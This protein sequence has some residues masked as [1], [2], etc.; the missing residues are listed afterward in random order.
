MIRRA[1][2]LGL[3]TSLLTSRAS[4]DNHVVT[5]SQTEGPFYPTEI[6]SDSDNDLVQIRGW[7]ARALGAVLHLQGRVFNIGGALV[8]GRTTVEIWQ[9]DSQGLYDHPRQSMRESRDTAFQGYGRVVVDS[10]GRYSFRTLKPVAY[11]G[12]TPHIHLKV[13]TADGRR[14]TTQF[15]LAGDPRNAGDD[16]WRNAVWSDPDRQAM[17]EM[18]LEPADGLEPGAVTTAMDIVMPSY[19]GPKA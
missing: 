2:V 4:A 7:P 19:V 17:I 10:Y 16:V 5:P 18:R 13:A 9:C 6:P 1:F 11:P 12:R 3:G 15:Y 14:L 8:R